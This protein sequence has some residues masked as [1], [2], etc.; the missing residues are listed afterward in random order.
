MTEYVIDLTKFTD[1]GPED[2]IVDLP[3]LPQVEK[4]LEELGVRTKPG[5]RKTDQALDLGLITIEDVKTSATLIA[6][7]NKTKVDKFPP[8]DL[9]HSHLDVN[10]IAL[11]QQFRETAGGWSPEIGKNR[12][13][14]GVHGA[15]HIGGDAY[16]TAAIEPTLEPGTGDKV[17]VGLIDTKLYPSGQFNGRVITLGE[18]YFKTDFQFNQ[19]NG[20]ATFTTGLILDTADGAAVI[21][22]AVL[23]DEDATATVWDVATAMAE[24]VDQNVSILVL[25]LA[26]SPEDGEAPLAM[27]RAV[28]ILRKKTVVVAAAGNHGDAKPGPKGEDYT[29]LAA[30]PAACAGAIAVGAVGRGD[31]GFA[32]VRFSPDLPWVQVVAPGHHV[33]SMFVRGDITFKPVPG[34]AVPTDS[35]PF[36]GGAT[37]SG[38]SFAAARF[39]GL[40][41]DAVAK[42]NGTAFEVAERLL[43]QKPLDGVGAYSLLP[44]EPVLD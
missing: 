24:F 32:R 41:A 39:G 10:V 37:W 4:A 17:R 15:P 42:G 2:I 30:F 20:H 19:L 11:R 43:Q 34:F 22:K 14:H 40:I 18:T 8:R 27:Q 16:P 31:T 12:T 9:P 5:S 6:K 1:Q 44:K 26:C 35:P 38:T 25:P 7:N 33:T 29:H 3:Y 13:M 23:S 28:N 36:K 21:A